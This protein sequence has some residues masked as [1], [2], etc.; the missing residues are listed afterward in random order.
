MLILILKLFGVVS[1]LFYKDVKF[2]MNHPRIKPLCA[3]IYFIT[4]IG[5]HSV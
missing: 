1:V 4:V 2:F 3:Q 5:S